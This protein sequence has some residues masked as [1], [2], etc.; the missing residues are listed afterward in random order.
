MKIELNAPIVTNAI[1]NA[2][3]AK[4][5]HPFTSG[6]TTGNMAIDEWETGAM[7]SLDEISH[8]LRTPL[9]S[10][11]GA[12]GL[13]LSGKVDPHTREGQQ[14]LRIAANN[15]KRLLRLTNA[16]EQDE[17]VSTS[18]ISN[19]ALERLRLEADL[20]TAWERKEFQVFFQPIVCLRSHCIL[21]FEAL[22]RWFHPTR[23]FV[24][25]TQFIPIAEETLLIHDL[26]LWVLEEACRQLHQWQQD[27]PQPS[28]LTCSVNLSALQLLHP[29]CV[30]SIH[31]IY[32]ASGVVIGTLRVE[33][34][35]SMFIEN[36]PVAIAALQELKSLNIPIYLDD[37]G[38]GYSSLARLHQL[39]VD[40]LKIDRAF[41]TREQWEMIRGILYLAESLGLDTIVEGIETREE[42]QCIENIGC[43]KVQ[44]FLFA[45]PLNGE[46]ATILL[47]NGGK[48]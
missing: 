15:T 3:D 36:S 21:G 47:Q 44:G 37:F 43:T 41:V 19:E 33:I 25:P 9:T 13:L 22:L 11:Q 40:V 17:A 10:I 1:G 27:F 29:D 4:P 12:L 20:Q 28:P 2:M 8:E 31:Q 30:Q 42:L 48:C 46:R 18:L 16:I 23:G 14:L 5:K 45:R 26:G 7:P 38:T 35:E 6:K 39:S 34:T 32:Q 24:S